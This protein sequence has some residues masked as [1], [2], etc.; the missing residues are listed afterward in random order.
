MIW[1]ARCCGVVR[2]AM[3]TLDAAFAAGGVTLARLFGAAERRGGDIGAQPF[4]KAT[5]MRSAGLGLVAVEVD[6]AV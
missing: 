5:I 2:T 1:C 6:L 3:I 4:G